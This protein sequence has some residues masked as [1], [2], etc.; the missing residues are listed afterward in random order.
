MSVRTDV[1]LQ[2]GSEEACLMLE[3][4]CERNSLLG[5]STTFSEQL[6]SDYLSAEKERKVEVRRRGTKVQGQL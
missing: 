5:A 3:A 6:K 1:L 4:D 2:T